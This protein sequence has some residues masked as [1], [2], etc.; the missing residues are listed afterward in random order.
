LWLPIQS[1][2]L[3]SQRSYEAHVIY[4][5]E[6]NHGQDFETEF[7]LS[8]KL[9]PGSQDDLALNIVSASSIELT[10]GWTKLTIQFNLSGN[11]LQLTAAIGRNRF[12][13]SNEAFPV[14]FSPWAIES[15]NLSTND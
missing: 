6:H 15:K 3:I 7:A 1:L 12:R 9:V 4:K 2:H 13:K 14:I 11:E 5:P 8:F 10:G